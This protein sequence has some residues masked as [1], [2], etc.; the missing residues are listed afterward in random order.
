VKHVVKADDNK[1]GHES[2][3]AEKVRP[4]KTSPV[5]KNQ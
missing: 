2:S 1:S 3:K 5:T 4:R